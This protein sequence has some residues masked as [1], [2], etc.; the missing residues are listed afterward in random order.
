LV[1]ADCCD[2]WSQVCLLS[3]VDEDIATVVDEL[4]D[5]FERNNIKVK[6]LH[7]GEGFLEDTTDALEQAA[8]YSYGQYYS[9]FTVHHLVGN[10]TCRINFEETE[11]H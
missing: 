10:G 1:G 6:R 3:W 11:Q 4:N 8:F 7:I 9:S 2:S 5:E